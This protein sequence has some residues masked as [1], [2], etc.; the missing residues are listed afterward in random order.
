MSCD[1]VRKIGLPQAG[2]G[3]LALL[4]AACAQPVQMTAVGPVPPGAARIWFYRDYEPSVSLNNATVTLNGAVAAQVSAF[5][6]GSYRDVPPGHYHIAVE[7][8][9]QDSNQT[10]DVDLGPGQEAFVKILDSTSWVEGGDVTEF[11]RDT[12]YVS[13]VS[14][15]VARAQM[16]QSGR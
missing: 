16:T 14:P 11:Q 5:G 4:L 12:F 13:L 2:A 15:Q 8:F 9:G 1:L 7:S 3:A 10:K 6:G